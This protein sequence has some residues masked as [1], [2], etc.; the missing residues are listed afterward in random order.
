MKRYIIIGSVT[1]IF[2]EVVGEVWREPVEVWIGLEPH[3]EELPL[4]VPLNLGI[5]IDATT[6]G[7]PSSSGGYTVVWP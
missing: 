4:V 3:M 5:T 2:L 1:V 6:S 7:G